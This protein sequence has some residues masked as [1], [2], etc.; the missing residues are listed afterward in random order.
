MIG[1]ID[2]GSG[3]QGLTAYL[4]AAEDH[5]GEAR[6]EAEIIG[7]SVLA[8]PGSNDPVRDISRQYGAFRRLRPELKNAVCHQI[9][10]LAPQDE[11]KLTNQQKAEIA[12]KWCAAMGYEAYTVVCHG[13]DWHVEA[14]RINPDGS[15]VPDAYEIRRSEKVMHQLRAEYGLIEI[16]PSHCLDAAAAMNHRKAPTRDQIA[17]AEKGEMPPSQIIANL[18]DE[19]LGDGPCSVV[20]L[21]EHLEA[22]GVGVRPNVAATGKFS[23]LAYDLGGI[24]VT[25][26]AMGRG[27]TWGNL[28][29]KGVSYV[30]DRD[31]PGLIGRVHAATQAGLGITG[32]A[33]TGGFRSGDGATAAAHQVEPGGGRPGPEIGDGGRGP[34]EVVGPD[35]QRFDQ[36]APAV[37]QGQGADGRHGVSGRPD[38]K[39]RAGLAR[40]SSDRRGGTP[41]ADGSG[42]REAVRNRRGREV[43]NVVADDR[44]GAFARLCA[45]ADLQDPSPYADRRSKPVDQHRPAGREGTSSER[46]GRGDAE[47][48]PRLEVDRT[49]R[50]IGQTLD[51]LPCDQ[52]VIGVRDAKTGKMMQRTW[53]RA[54]VEKSTRWLKR[55][56]ALGSDIY[57]RPASDNYVLVDDLS[58]AQLA[59][60]RTMGFDPALVTE[61]SKDNHQAWIRLEGVTP[62]ER[63]VLGRGLAQ[64]VGGDPASAGREHFGRL[65]GFT[66]TKPSRTLDNG[67]Q[68]FVLVREAVGALATKAK[69]LVQWARD[70]VD[71]NRKRAAII[72][73]TATPEFGPSPWTTPRGNAVDQFQAHAKAFHDK[74]V[75]AGDPVDWS[76][77]DFKAAQS[78][79]ANG[80]GRDDIAQ[81]IEASAERKRDPAAYAAKTAEAACGSEWAQTKRA[82]VEAKLK[83]D[84]DARA[85]AETDAKAKAEA[86][87]KTEAEARAK[88]PV[89]PRFMPKPPSPF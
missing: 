13:P 25:A 70:T 82:E 48:G 38:D 74:A 16:A 12:D 35:K 75:K 76:K 18:I 40:S 7:G 3:F 53:D 44:S 5:K 27:Y 56:N 88:A 60:L 67:F 28:E 65:P 57:I 68:P 49:R 69:E 36:P 37:G 41:E 81:G 19:R 58:A 32:G 17:M 83:T 20:Q 42:I 14:S 85:K 80:W 29:K 87:A 47:P 73:T 31:L 21:I 63:T 77:I 8:V 84:A 64:L 24:I 54:Q 46:D 26:K 43:L 11:G 55:Q 34:G 33:E 71:D 22:A 72:A 78:M 86:K 66:N 51:A 30:E 89:A 39:D 4:L 59:K 1:K 23:G 2:S 10:R 62:E 45:L 6:T 79:Y 15:V 9:F 50:A 61:T 52:Y